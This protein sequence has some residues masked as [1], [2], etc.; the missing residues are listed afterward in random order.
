MDLRFCPLHC[1]MPRP[2]DAR[3]RFA[4]LP[5][6]P[7]A[8]RHP[9]A[10]RPQRDPR[11][12][13]LSASP[14]LLRSSMPPQ[15][16]KAVCGEG[17]VG[18]TAAWDPRGQDLVAEITKLLDYIGRTLAACDT[19]DLEYPDDGSGPLEVQLTGSQAFTHPPG[20]GVSLNPGSC[21]IPKVDR[22]REVTGLALMNKTYMQVKVGKLSSR[23]Y[24]WAPIN[25]IL[26]WACYGGPPAG[27]RE[28]VSMHVCTQPAGGMKCLNAEHMVWGES[29]RNLGRWEVQL[30]GAL[31][32]A[33]DRMLEQRRFTFW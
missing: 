13:Y 8:I 25:Q 22:M 20:Q 30:R 2:R 23:S 26:L 12:F 7:V 11:P 15:L 32:E 33:R 19:T 5:R 10:A 9:L 28:P 18:P 6:G 4:S 14:A 1:A 16:R 31:E 3:G 29:V 21:I 27:I 24:I 17:H